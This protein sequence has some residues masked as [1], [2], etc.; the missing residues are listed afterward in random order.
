MENALSVKNCRAVLKALC[1][2][3]KRLYTHLSAK[4]STKVQKEFNFNAFPSTSQDCVEDT[5]LS[6]R[7]KIDDYFS[8]DEESLDLILSRMTAKD[9]FSFNVFTTSTDLKNS[10]IAKGYNDLPTSAVSIR[11][12]VGDYRSQIKELITRE[13]QTFKSSGKKLV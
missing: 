6:K 9:G 11:N 4:H 8:T 13:I 3:N 7:W 2:S 10:L 1:G 5:F 12:R